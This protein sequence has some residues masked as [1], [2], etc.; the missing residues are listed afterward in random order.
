MRAL[1]SVALSL[2]GV[3]FVGYGTFRSWYEDRPGNTLPLSDLFVGVQRE[4]ATAL[5]SILLPLALGALFAVV[6]VV[7]SKGILQLGGVLL[8]L[9]CGVWVWQA[10]EVVDIGDLQ[11]G[12]WNATFGS[13]LVL[14]A[15]IMRPGRM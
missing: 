3:G 6:G 5:T 12:V 14:A 1:I 2:V 9:T 7:R 11:V 8:V 13:M 4:T 10:R 15:G